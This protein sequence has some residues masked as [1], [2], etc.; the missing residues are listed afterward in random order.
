MFESVGKFHCG[1]WNVLG[2]SAVSVGIHTL[3]NSVIPV[4][5][6]CDIHQISRN[7]ASVFVRVHGHRRGH[8]FGG[9]EGMDFGQRFRHVQGLRHEHGRG[10]DT[11]HE[12]Q[13][14]VLSCVCDIFFSS[15]SHKNGQII[16][17]N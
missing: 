11:C 6:S 13:K 1:Y 3:E 5:W 9:K 14:I 16:V 7:F 8:G 2:M 4:V 12:R 10:H 17:K 15:L